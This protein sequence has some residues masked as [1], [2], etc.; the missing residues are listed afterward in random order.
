MVPIRSGSLLPLLQGEDNGRS[1]L[2]DTLVAAVSNCAVEKA[3]TV[4]ILVPR[5][6]DAYPEAVMVMSL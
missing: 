1:D 3:T 2:K 6:E 4:E 5:P